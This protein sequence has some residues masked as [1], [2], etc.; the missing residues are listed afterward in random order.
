MDRFD[1]A[2]HGGSHI[3]AI[4][5]SEVEKA[6]IIGVESDMLF[7]IDEQERLAQAFEQAGAATTYAPLDCI[8][9]HDS[10]LIDIARFGNEMRR[11]LEKD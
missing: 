11:F 2:A 3:A 5:R 4:K 10:F 6:L 9:G 8:E 7:A 1:L